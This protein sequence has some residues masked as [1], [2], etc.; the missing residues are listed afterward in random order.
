VVAC[1]AFAI[2]IAAIIA[3]R[4]AAIHCKKQWIYNA[5]APAMALSPLKTQEE[6]TLHRSIPRPRSMRINTQAP[7][8]AV[9]SL[10]I[11]KPRAQRKRRSRA[12]P[13]SAHTP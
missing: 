9:F 10:R 8:S 7:K 2:S 13:G 6:I 5:T 1:V 4:T 3:V 11:G 12:K